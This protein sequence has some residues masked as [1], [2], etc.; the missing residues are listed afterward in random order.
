MSSGARF[1]ESERWADLT[2]RDIVKAN[3]ISANIPEERLDINY[4]SFQ[5]KHCVG[6]TLKPLITTVVVFNS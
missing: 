1:G 4:E 3:S 2:I 6:L 5:G